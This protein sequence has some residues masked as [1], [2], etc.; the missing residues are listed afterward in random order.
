MIVD[1]TPPEMSTVPAD[2]VPPVPVLVIDPVWLME[3]VINLIPPAIELLFFKSKTRLAFPPVVPPLIV[4]N[5]EPELLLLVSVVVP[6]VFARV[7]APETVSAEVVEFSVIPVTLAPIP[8]LINVAPVPVPLL[9]I[10]PVL[11]TEFVDKVMLLSVVLLFCNVK[12]PVPVIPPVTVSAE[13]VVLI[14]LNVPTV[15]AVVS[16]VSGELPF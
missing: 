15:I 12:L 4:N 16:I 7:I 9:V 13:P 14:K 11:F 8:A 2:D 3:L 5:A 6:L 1:P 10:V